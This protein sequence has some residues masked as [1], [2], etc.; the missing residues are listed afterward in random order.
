MPLRVDPFIIAL[1]SAAALGVV[2]PLTGEA[3]EVGRAVQVVVIAGLFFLYGLRIPTREVVRGLKSWHLHLLV[4]VLT[5]AVFPLLGW[6]VSFL[7]PA[8][9]A[10]GIVLLCLVPTTQNSSV[11][12]TSIAGGDRA[13]AVVTTALS[14]LA[15]VF[16]TPALVA[17]LLSSDAQVDASTFLRIVAMILLPF[18]AGQLAQRF[19]PAGLDRRLQRYDRFSVLYVVYLGFSGGTEAGVWDLV[20]ATDL[21]IILAWCVV[22]LVVMSAL[23]LGASWSLTPAQ[24]KAVYFTGTNK[25]LAA[26]LPMAAVLFSPGDVALMILPLM[27]YHQLQI[28]VGTVIAQ[29]WGHG[30]EAG[31]RE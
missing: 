12:C 18:L 9:V 10:P 4:L 20:G 23:S 27:I 8:I 30:V 25:S 14:S 31:E 22:L 1:V 6:G 7:V 19:V 15:G 26:G 16:L 29:R 13:L 28:L 11:V 17:L 2:L 5:F 3:L 21:A 24:R